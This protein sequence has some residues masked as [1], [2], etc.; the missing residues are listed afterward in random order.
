MKRLET[1]TLVGIDCVDLDRLLL[2]M[3]ICQKDFEF[4]EVKILSS[5]E[6]EKSDKIIKIDPLNSL[7]EYSHFVIY[8][9]DKYI[10]T[11]HVLIVQHDGFIL[12]PAAWTDEFLDYDY[13]GAPWLVLNWLVEKCDF[14]AKLIGQRVVGNGGFSL[15]SKKL[16]TLIAKLAREGRF[17]R[18]NFED[19]A[20]C[21]YY[22]QLLEDQGIRFAPVELAQRFSFESEGPDNYQWDG[23]FGFH[24][25]KWTGI[26]KW[27]EAHPEYQIDN[28]AAD[29]A[30]RLD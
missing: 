6:S 13:I 28:P 22:R 27:A 26:S 10:E 9:L 21:V 5:L 4:A 15:R 17:E 25:L 1:V 8:E 11:D 30:L 7:E 24:G 16:L 29:E 14:P 18:Y 20:I 12:N 23:Q 3:E 19:V 2:A